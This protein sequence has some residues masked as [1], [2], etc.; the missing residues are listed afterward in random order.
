MASGRRPLLRRIL[1][2]PLEALPLF[3]LLGISRLLPVDRASALGGWIVRKIA[4]RIAGLRRR[5]ERGLAIAFPDM[6]E[7]ERQAIARRMLDNFGRLVFEYPHL[8]TIARPE[9]GRI[10]VVGGEILFDLVARKQPAIL[11]GG[12]LGNFEIVPRF[13]AGQGHRLNIFAR[14]PNNAILDHALKRWRGAARMFDR[15]F[16]SG[17][18]AAHALRRGEYVAQ[19]IDQRYD[20]G[21]AVPFFGQEAM[22]NPAMARTALHLKLPVVPCRVQRLEGARFRITVEEP[23]PLPDSGDRDADVAALT[24]AMT[25]R[26]EAWVRDDPGQWFWLHRRWPKALYRG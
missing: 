3:I 24:A 16:S 6:P 11:I 13:V 17:M 7:A 22:T 20:S 9:N 19:L 18:Q 10:E 21:L 14:G 4:P 2:D 26:I 5:S 8:P 12:H 1:Q 15:G 23:L 25:A